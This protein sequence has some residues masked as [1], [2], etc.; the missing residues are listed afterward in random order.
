MEIHIAGLHVQVGY[1]F[2][3]RCGWCGATLIDQDL[4]Q[5]M[6]PEGTD[7]TPSHWEPGV[8]VALEGP[9]AYVYPHVAGTQLPLNAC[10]QLDH[11]ITR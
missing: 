2:R 9:Q 7:S 11:E 4:R 6:I 5:V 3:Q 1:Q 10:A 8:L